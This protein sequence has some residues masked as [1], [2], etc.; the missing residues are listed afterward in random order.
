MKPPLIPAP[1]QVRYKSGALTLERR[2]R[3]IVPAETPPRVEEIV[4]ILRD[5]LRE[6]AGIEAS[7]G[8]NGEGGTAGT[9][10]LVLAAVPGTADPEAYTLEVGRSIEITA[11][12]PRGLLWGV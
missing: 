6:E 11:S 10:R 3:I 5:G 1:Q 4:G 2:T 9:I 8:P 12:D 7:L